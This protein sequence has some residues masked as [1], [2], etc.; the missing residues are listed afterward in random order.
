MDHSA[1]SGDPPNA[2]LICNI[3]NTHSVSKFGHCKKMCISRVEH[4]A[5]Q[6]IFV[7]TFLAKLKNDWGSKFG[8]HFFRKIMR[9]NTLFVMNELK[10]QNRE[11]EYNHVMIMWTLLPQTSP[12]GHILYMFHLFVSLYVQISVYVESY[13]TGSR[14]GLNGWG[15]T[16]SFWT[17]SFGGIWHIPPA[18]FIG[19][20]HILC[21]FYFIFL[22][23]KT[24][25]C[26]MF[27]WVDKCKEINKHWATSLLLTFL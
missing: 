22:F 13:K 12:H 11:R 27:G 25:V 23:W 7:E 21:L 19:I 10:F 3:F 5:L 8:A 2:H 26:L 4:N 18:Y 16:S 1:A 14:P 24:I 6:C 15:T 9:K 20:W 17:H